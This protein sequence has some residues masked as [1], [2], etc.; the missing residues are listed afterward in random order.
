MEQRFTM[1][2]LGVKD[3]ARS[4]AFYENGLGWKRSSQSNDNIVFF[5]MGGVLIGLYSRTGLAEDA[6]VPADGSGFPGIALAHN[7]RSKEA[8]DAVLA[9]AARAGATILKPA[10]DVFWGGYSG[11]FADPDGH[12]W[13]VAFNPFWTIAED[14]SVVLPD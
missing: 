3:L 2:S 14:G 1:V 7:V 4:A 10:Q 9:E 8:V 6:N 12:L 13:E 5:D 11:Y